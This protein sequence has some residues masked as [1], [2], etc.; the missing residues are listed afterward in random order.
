M[1][2]FV[3]VLAALAALLVP[4][5]PALAAAAHTRGDSKIPSELCLA[6]LGSDFERTVCSG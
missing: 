2:R 5:A 4:T 3:V 6:V 1:K